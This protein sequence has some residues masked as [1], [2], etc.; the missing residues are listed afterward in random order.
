MNYR[1][2]GRSKDEFREQIQKRI[3]RENELFHRWINS[4]EN[5]PK[6]VYNGCGL[7]GEYLEDDQVTS[8]ADYLVDGYGPF[9]TKYS[10]PMITTYFHLKVS[11]VNSYL[12]Q[13]ATIL[14]IN[15]ANTESPEYT[16]ITT[17]LLKDIANTCSIVP[18]AGFGGKNAY[19]ISV[20]KFEWSKLG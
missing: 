6:Y 9:E 12:K 18:F 20:Q 16:I 8:D 19:K 10:G 17:K 5:P 4:H 2:D 14:M 1:Q 15:G 13:K 11:N 3:I 7:N